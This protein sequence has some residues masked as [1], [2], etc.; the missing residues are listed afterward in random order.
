MNV[1]AEVYIFLILSALIP[2]IFIGSITYN[3][4]ISCEFYHFRVFSLNNNQEIEV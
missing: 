3:T 2:I 4:L 1:L